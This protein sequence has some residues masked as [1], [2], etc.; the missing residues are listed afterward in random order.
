MKGINYLTV[1]PAFK[2]HE[3]ENAAISC[4]EPV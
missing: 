1:I 2:F 4:V 3:H